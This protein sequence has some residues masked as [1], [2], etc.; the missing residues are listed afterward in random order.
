MGLVPIRHFEIQDASS[1]VRSVLPGWKPAKLKTRA[2]YRKA[3]KAFLQ[4]SL[5]GFPFSS[6]REI[7]GVV[8]D[9]TL[10]E[11]VLIEIQKDLKTKKD[12]D[13]LVKRLDTFKDWGAVILVILVGSVSPVFAAKL[14][15][16][17]NFLNNDLEWTD[18][19]DIVI[20]RK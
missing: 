4:K 13:T 9:I 16:H 14:D 2:A 8:S 10:S 3:L 15:D 20:L 5:E 11:E 12:Y 19:K 1:R 17:V 6:E 18:H 7:A